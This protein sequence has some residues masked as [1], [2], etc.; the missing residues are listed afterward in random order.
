[1]YTIKYCSQDIIYVE[2]E[3]K[4]RFTSFHQSF[5]QTTKLVYKQSQTRLYILYALLRFANS[6]FIVRI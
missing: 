2:F 4:L 6:N 5:I 1:M 3:F